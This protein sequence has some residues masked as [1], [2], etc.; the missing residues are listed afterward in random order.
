MKCV[1]KPLYHSNSTA[2][3]YIFVYLNA[4]SI[5]SVVPFMKYFIQVFQLS[6]EVIGESAYLKIEQF[7][8]KLSNKSTSR[9]YSEYGKV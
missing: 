3:N 9:T 8:N 1:N 4:I 5:L 6:V 2:F 7:L